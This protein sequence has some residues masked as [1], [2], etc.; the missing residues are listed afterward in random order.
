MKHSSIKFEGQNTKGECVLRLIWVNENTSSFNTRNLWPGWDHSKA[1]YDWVLSP[2]YELSLGFLYTAFSTQHLISVQNIVCMGGTEQEPS[3]T[4]PPYNFATNQFFSVLKLYGCTT[5]RDFSADTLLI[6]FK[7][8]SS[9][10]NIPRKFTWV[11]F[12]KRKLLCSLFNF[13]S[14]SYWIFSFSNI[15]LFSFACFNAFSCFHSFF[16]SIKQHLT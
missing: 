3:I 11:S 16:F 2:F 6:H 9:S 13:R 4:L 15:I 12:F 5:T 10:K 1:V 14:R 7:L 8:Y